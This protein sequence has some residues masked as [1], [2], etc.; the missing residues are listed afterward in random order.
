MNESTLVIINYGWYN[1]IKLAGAQ[2]GHWT[3][4]Q[5]RRLYSE[6]KH[7]DQ[8]RADD[9]FDKVLYDPKSAGIHRINQ[10]PYKQYEVYGAPAGLKQR[11]LGVRTGTCFIWYWIG[12]H[13]EYNKLIKLEPPSGEIEAVK[14][15]IRKK[16]LCG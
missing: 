15:Y 4:A 6:M 5:F 12:S 7:D 10:N 9:K 3:T 2:S 8:A 16:G 11:V 14:A 1:K 13:E